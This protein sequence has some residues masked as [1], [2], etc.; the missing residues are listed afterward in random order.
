[1]AGLRYDEHKYIE[2]HGHDPLLFNLDKDPGEKTNLASDPTMQSVV[3]DMKKRISKWWNAE[4]MQ[5]TVLQSQRERM[6]IRDALSKGEKFPWDF[7]PFF[8][9]SKMYV[10]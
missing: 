8:D 7:Q 1:M 9:A 10:R 6:L 3:N 2:V 4:E 5:R